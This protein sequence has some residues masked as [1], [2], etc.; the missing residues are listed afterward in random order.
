MTSPS[1]LDHPLASYAVHTMTN[2]PWTLAQCCDRYASAGFGGVSVWRNVI[3]PI[4]FGEAATIVR[5]SGLRVPSLVR[6]GFFVS[7]SPSERQRAV[8]DNK[9]CLDEAAAIG[10]DMV[11][12]VPG[13]EPGLP[14]EQ[15]R[16]QVADGIASCL[17]HADSVGVRL[18][19]EPLHPM[20]AADKSCINR[21]REARLVCEKLDDPLVGVAI[22]A[23]HVWWDPE[24]ASEITELGRQGR[25]FGFH[26]CDWRIETRHLLTDRAIPGEGCINL[27]QLDAWMAAAGF[28]GAVEIEIFSEEHWS[29]D[30]D[31]YLGRLRSAVSP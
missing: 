25:L 16:G 22:D 31:A 23:Y 2:K 10:A 15:A 18:A 7:S 28:Q 9:R 30:Q 13:A 8:D 1:G 19:I 24:L 29:D 17:P 26:V 5:G 4:G 27:Q 20:Y 21:A 6:G 14:L 3:E 11:V 12:L